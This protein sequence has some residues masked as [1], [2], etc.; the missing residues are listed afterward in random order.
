MFMWAGVDLATSCRLPSVKHLL[1]FVFLPPY[2]SLTCF[3]NT[4]LPLLCTHLSPTLTAENEALLQMSKQTERGEEGN[5]AVISFIRY[6]YLE[7]KYIV[8][9]VINVSTFLGDVKELLAVI[10]S[11]QL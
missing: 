6:D 7:Y 5:S 1:Y 2:F 9:Q 3:L 8:I 4:L 11:A 10:S